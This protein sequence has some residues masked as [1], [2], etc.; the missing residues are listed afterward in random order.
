MDN[1]IKRTCD[2]M[3][4]ASPSPSSIQDEKKSGSDHT[5]IVLS[6]SIH[7]LLSGKA[8]A[9]SDDISVTSHLINIL[10]AIADL[11]DSLTEI[12]HDITVT[13][14]AVTSI[15]TDMSSLKVIVSR[16][17]SKFVG[18]TNSLTSLSKRTDIIQSDLPAQRDV[19]QL[20][21]EKIQNIEEHV[22]EQED[23]TRRSNLRLL[24]L[25]EGQEGSDII[26][27]L[28]RHLPIWLP[29]LS[30]RGVMEIERAHRIYS[31]SSGD[32]KPRPVIFRLLRYS[33]RKAILDAY[34]AAGSSLT[35]GSHKLL[36]FADYSPHT[37]R[38]RMAFIMKELRRK[39]VQNFLLYPAKLK[40]C[41]NKETHL[42]YSPD[43]D[44]KFTEG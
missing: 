32:N 11:K 14:A 3:E 41:H 36:L 1:S 40:V 9:A 39:G 26:G 20:N 2:L 25:P 5:N 6:P 19:T 38:C 27:F 43:E 37:S 31:K 35:Y 8:P 10:Q 29:T 33:D 18:L 23:Y 17:E 13:G 21:K 7:T 28:Q 44:Q 16:M 42:F 15:Q 34:R 30:A 4:P 22:A 12:R 24:F